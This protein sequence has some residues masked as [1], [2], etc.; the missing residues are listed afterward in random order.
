MS[1]CIP[2]PHRPAELKEGERCCS[3]VTKVLI[4]PRILDEKKASE[5]GDM[6]I[7]GNHAPIIE[8]IKEK[9]PVS[10]ILLSDATSG[11][12]RLATV[13]AAM[14][15]AP[16]IYIKELSKCDDEDFLERYFNDLNVDYIKLGADKSQEIFN[17]FKISGLSIKKGTKLTEAVTEILGK[18][19]A[20]ISSGVKKIT[21]KSGKDYYA[22]RQMNRKIFKEFTREKFDYSDPDGRFLDLIFE[23]NPVIV[24]WSKSGLSGT[25]MGGHPEHL[26]GKTATSQIVTLAREVGFKVAV[27]GD[28]T[29]HNLDIDFDLRHV[30]DGK[31]NGLSLTQQYGAIKYINYFKPLLNMSMRSG[32]IEPLPLLGVRTVYLEDLF[33]KQE[34]RMQNLQAVMP[35]KYARQ[36]FSVPPTLKGQ[37]KQLMIFFYDHGFRAKLQ[38]DP[39]RPR[40]EQGIVMLCKTLDTTLPANFSYADL[41]NNLLMKEKLDALFKSLPDKS[42]FKSVK[43]NFR[44]AG[45][46]R[47]FITDDINT[48]RARLTIE[49][50]SIKLGEK[51]DKYFP[52]K[53]DYLIEQID[54]LIK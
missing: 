29:I 43:N 22:H 4:M 48:L 13:Y 32:Q 31:L 40:L 49:G 5:L 52:R 33:N 18:R 11:D 42:E 2:Q 37:L 25:F 16:I 30:H 27:A 20:E 35:K 21:S 17:K 41:A 23:T 15:N 38:N 9:S 47:G 19:E 6:Y 50:A 44:D 1:L 36:I 39:L 12:A 7:K 45:A 46:T 24:I 3:N 10:P 28:L 54:L 51:K 53:L 14:T 26:F 8:A 34:A